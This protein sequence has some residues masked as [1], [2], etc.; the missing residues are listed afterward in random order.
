MKKLIFFFLIFTFSKSFAQL[1]NVQKSLL[2]NTF[3]FSKTSAVTGREEEA[4]H[5]V[6]NLF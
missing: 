4:I 6:K 3:E 2:S 5:F 1:S